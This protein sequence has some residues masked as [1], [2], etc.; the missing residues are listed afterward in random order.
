MF[1]APEEHEELAELVDLE[2]HGELVEL[3]ARRD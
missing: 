2:A 1:L 3:V